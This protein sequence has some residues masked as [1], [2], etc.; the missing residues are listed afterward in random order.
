MAP[1]QT[2]HIHAII[3]PSRPPHCTRWFMV[4]KNRIIGDIIA[5]SPN[6]I[7]GHEWA[8]DGKAQG[9]SSEKIAR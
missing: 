3:P 1:E 4:E 5:I 9:K 6:T 7:E 8:T 2:G